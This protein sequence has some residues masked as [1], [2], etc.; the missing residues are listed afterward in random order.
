MSDSRP[1]AYCTNRQEWRQWLVANFESARE[2]WFVFP[3]KASGEVGVAY[4]D[5]VEEALCFGWIDGVAGTL[6]PL[7]QLRR[8]TPRRKGSPYSR[9]NIERLIW[10]NEQGLLHPSVR[11]SVADLITLPF[12]FPADIIAT[13]QQDQKV[14]EHY[15]AFSEPYKRIRVAYID[16]ARKRPEEFKRRLDNFLAKTRQNRL[17]VGYGGIEKYYST[18][19]NTPNK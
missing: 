1:I 12:Q 10:L 7:H 2:V 9:P 13:L 3:T 18:A 11:T 5:A 16:A 19:H 6:D 17:I 14:W 4:N 8:F 15:C